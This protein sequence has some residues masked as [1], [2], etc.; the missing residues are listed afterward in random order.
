[1]NN[2][3]NLTINDHEWH[4]NGVGGAPFFTVAFTLIEDGKPMDL[5]AI[6]RA[7]DDYTT[8]VVS[9]WM[10]IDPTDMHSNWRGDRIGHHLKPLFEKLLHDE[11]QE[12]QRNR[13]P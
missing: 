9:E 13:H 6:T 5:I 10:V 2:Q 4:R 3:M 1:M 8:D 7:I 11:E 12:R